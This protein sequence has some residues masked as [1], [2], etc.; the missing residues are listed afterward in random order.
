[1]A[2]FRTSLLLIVTLVLATSAPTILE[3]QNVAATSS[4]T[5]EE[6]KPAKEKKAI[7][8]RAKKPYRTWSLILAP[9]FTNPLTDIRYNDFFGATKPKAEYQFGGLR[10]G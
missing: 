5:T 4:E 2:Y 10:V 6:T 8:P 9:G 3:A 7:N 1:M